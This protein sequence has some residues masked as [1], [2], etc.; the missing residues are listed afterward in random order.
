[1]LFGKKNT[2]KVLS[3]SSK[4]VSVVQKDPFK[5]IYLTGF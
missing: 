1:M 2:G 3:G 5:D 4:Y